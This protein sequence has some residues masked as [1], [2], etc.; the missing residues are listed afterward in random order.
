MIPESIFNAE[1]LESSELYIW[2]SVAVF[3]VSLMARILQKRHD[4]TY[5]ATPISLSVMLTYAVGFTVKEYMVVVLPLILSLW[6]LLSD[7]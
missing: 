7:R 4:A 6:E 5:V 1:V 2:G 3:W